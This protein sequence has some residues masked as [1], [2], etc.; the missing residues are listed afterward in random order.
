MPNSF[1][2]PPVEYCSRHQPHPGCK[3]S[4][5][6]EGSA[7]ADRSHD[8]CRDQRTDAGD[9]SESQACSIG[10][11]DLLHFMVQ[12]RPPVA[13]APSTRPRVERAGFASAALDPHRRSRGPPA[14][15]SRSLAGLLANTRPRSSRKARNWLMTEVRRV[16]RRSRTRWS[17]LQIELVICLDRHEPHVLPIDC[18]GDRFG[19]QE[20]VLVRLYKRLHELRRNQLHVV[21]L[22]SQGAA[23]EVRAGAGF[24]A[25]SG[26]SA[27]SL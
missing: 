19:I 9:L 1:A 7:V 6:V 18:L 8:G 12:I 4:P 16:I 2:L 22:F 17:R 13:R 26:T 3:L 5:L 24:Q 21:A 20:V 10:R 25:R 15:R 27:G 23:Q 11:G 14:S